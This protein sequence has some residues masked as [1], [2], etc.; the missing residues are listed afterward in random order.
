MG[1]GPGS[2]GQ[3]T[4]AAVGRFYA[5]DALRAPEP[6]VALDFLEG[7]HPLVVR[8]GQALGRTAHVIAAEVTALL[9][10]HGF[11]VGQ[12]LAP[13]KYELE[14]HEVLGV[15]YPQRPAEQRDLAPARDKPP[16]VVDGRNEDVDVE[17]GHRPAELPLGAGLRCQ[18]RAIA[19]RRETGL[20]GRGQF[21]GQP[22]CVR[23][24]GSTKRPGV[25]KFGPVPARQERQLRL[26]RRR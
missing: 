6:G 2:A 1:G 26:R 16:V 12:V 15:E 21:A 17:A 18:G 8:A 9:A 23:G 11:H 13:K 4:T 7:A 5:G 19:R 3:T 24:D 25:G 22:P 14:H 20:P 10:E